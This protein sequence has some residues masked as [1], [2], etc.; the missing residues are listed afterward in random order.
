MEVS[1]LGALTALAI[2]IFLIIKKVHPFYALLI[3]AILGGLLGG[4]SVTNCIDLITSGTKEMMGPI[5]RILCAGI[6]A[7]VLIESGAA[8]KIAYSIINTLGKKYALI[9]LILATY[10]ITAAGVFIYVAVITIAPV[11][12]VTA[13]EFNFSKTAILVALIGGGKAGNIVSPNPNT[14]VAATHFNLDLT[15]LMVAGIIP[16][17]FGVI[18]TYIIAKMLVKKGIPIHDNQIKIQNEN[19]PSLLSALSGPLFAIFLLSLN[20]MASIKIDPIIA[21]PLGAL[22][23]CIC[24]KKTKQLNNYAKFGISKIMDIVVILI[25]TGAIAGIITGSE[26]KNDIINLVTSLHI[27]PILLA[28]ISGILMGAA[29]ASTTSGTAVASSVFGNTLL[30]FNF[31]PLPIAAMMHSGATVLDHLPH[32]SFFHATG[33]SVFMSVKERLG[34]IPYETIIGFVMC[35]V[36]TLI[37]SFF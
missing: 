24:M 33:G 12:L 18:A 36:S 1:S 15:D 32:G 28:P 19:L 16:S 4:A 5:L 34:I 31:K 2:A 26:F 13:K 11:A 20:P 29:T 14:V 10:C 23:G 21:L 17:I 6:L 30:G 35:L 3:G 9:A 22:F 7:G 27:S 25:G 8:N 37:Y